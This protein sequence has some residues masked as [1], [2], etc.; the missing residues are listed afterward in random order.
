M[1][2]V[3]SWRTHLVDKVS[4]AEGRRLPAAGPH[5]GGPPRGRRARQTHRAG[6]GRNGVRKAG[7][8]SRLT[9]QPP[10]APQ[11]HKDEIMRNRRRMKEINQYVDH[12]QSELDSL[13]YSDLL[14]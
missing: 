11:I 7:S 5:A 6:A 4:A 13:E 3:N 12:V 14:D 9:G 10:Y 2:R 1:T 8:G